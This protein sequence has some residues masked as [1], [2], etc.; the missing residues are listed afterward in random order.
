MNFTIYSKDG[1]KFCTKAKQLLDYTKQKYV[2]YNLDQHFTKEQFQEEFGVGKG[3]PQVTVNGKKLGGCME[4][5]Q[6]LKEQKLF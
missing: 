1:C 3:F 5:L 2:V 6:Y 4:T